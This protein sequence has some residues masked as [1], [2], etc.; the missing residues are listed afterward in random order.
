MSEKITPA[1][2]WAQPRPKSRINKWK[3]F[4]A[5]ALTVAALHWLT[6]RMPVHCPHSHHPHSQHTT[7]VGENIE[8][9]PCGE[10]NNRPLEC[11]SIDVPI[12]QFNPDASNKTF[13]V[14]I[15]RLRGKDG[16][17]N[18]L[19]NPGGPGG[20]GFEFLHRRGE[21]LSTIVGDGLHLLTFDPRGINSSTPLASCYP[22]KEAR[23]Q[24]G[25][26]HD[27]DMSKD[28][29][30]VFA[31]THNYVR[32]CEDTMGEHG[33]YINTPQTAADMNSILDAVGQKD[34]YYWGFSY[35]TL[36]GQTYATLF[37]KRSHRVIIDGVVNQFLWYQARLD[38]E[39]LVDTENVFDGLLKECFKSGDACPLFSMADSWQGLKKKFVSFVGD[40]KE[41]PMNVYVNNSVYGLLDYQKIWYG[42]LFPVLYK[43][44]RWYM[45]AEKMEQLLRG[46][47][48]PALM[49][50]GLDGE[51]NSDALYTVSLNDGL[52]GPEHWPQ[53]LDSLLEIVTPTFN[54]SVF[55]PDD[56]VYLFAKQQWRIPKTHNY[57]PRNGVET[58]HPLLILTTSYDPVCPLVSARSA[59]AA[60]KDSRLVE[61][62]GYGHCSVAAP[63]LCLA[64]HV[65][66]FL[67]NGTLPA[68]NETQCEVDGPYF[69]PNGS[70]TVQT[71]ED[72]ED[73]AIYLAQVELARDGDWPRPARL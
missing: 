73:Q 7:Y 57:V 12:D 48:T 71:F 26:V 53:D 44:E 19:L 23:Q 45:F 29:P 66:G 41:Q 13:N 18:L 55:A 67:Y 39:D 47:A 70:A 22:T 15:A 46:N 28:G 32:A 62:K 58:A 51:G 25:S 34:M 40:L 2:I 31:W 54:R 36:L 20:S 3:V 43:P 49:E 21:Q 8:W 24:L 37:P 27:L 63:S 69:K 10:I 38:G 5:G 50:Y 1:D 68:A 9:K 16:S 6:P 30:E 60:F 17:P 14:A 72:A 4:G 35:G 56:L 33:K 11:S 59:L 42:A 64:K 52:A 65:R 61:V